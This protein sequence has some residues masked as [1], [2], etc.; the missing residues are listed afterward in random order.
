MRM[1]NVVVFM[2]PQFLIVDEYA[3]VAVCVAQAELP[4]LEPRGADC[5]EAQAKKSWTFASASSREQPSKSITSSSGVSTSTWL[6]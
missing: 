2:A 6:S 1:I 3:T 5:Y 4:T